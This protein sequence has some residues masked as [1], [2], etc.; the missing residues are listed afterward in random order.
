MTGHAGVVDV[1]PYHVHH[2]VARVVI[3]Q[4]DVPV[5]DVDVPVEQE[6]G[7]WH[8]TH[9]R[10]DPGPV[11]GPGTVLGGIVSQCVVIPGAV[12]LVT[13]PDHRITHSGGH[14]VRCELARIPV[15]AAGGADFPPVRRD[16][17]G[18]HLL[19]QDHS[20]GA[21]IGAEPLPPVSVAARGIGE[22]GLGPFRPRRVR[23]VV[24][25]HAVHLLSGELVEAVQG[26]P[27]ASRIEACRPGVEWARGPDGNDGPA[28]AG[29]HG[30]YRDTPA[31]RP[32]ANQAPGTLSVPPGR[33]RRG[34]P[35]ACRCR[36][37]GQ[38]ASP[39]RPHHRA[40]GWRRAVARP[41]NR[42]AK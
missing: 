5:A 30:G 21:G 40:P 23:V 38:G 25:Q 29:Q 36:R 13:E 18:H 35:A 11:R 7:T 10:H 26:A 14:Q 34:F 1:D 33:T 39:S 15:V 42:P 8:R 16:A 24:Q 41:A 3:I 20:A 19:G 22:P 12:H 4:G 17:V 2:A 37:P 32:P 9:R 28:E 31:D 6:F 27:T